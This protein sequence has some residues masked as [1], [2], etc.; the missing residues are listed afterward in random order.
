MGINKSFRRSYGK[1]QSSSTSFSSTSFSSSSSPSATDDNDDR[2]NNHHD[3][4]SEGSGRRHKNQ[5]RPSW[6]KWSSSRSSSTRGGRKTK[7][8][9]EDK[10][11][12]NRNN[13][14]N[15]DDDNDNDA[16]GTKKNQ[17]QQPPISPSASPEL[18][19]AVR[20]FEITTKNVFTNE[21]VKKKYKRLSL[22]HHPDRNGNEKKSI[23]EMQKIN[24]YLELLEEELDR[25]V[26]ETKSD[27]KVDGSEDDP[28][29][30]PNSN[31]SDN[32]DEEK[33]DNKDKYKHAKSSR[34]TSHHRRRSRS[35]F[36]SRS[37]TTTRQGHESFDQ[38][39]NSK[40][41][42]KRRRCNS[43]STGRR[44]RKM[45]QQQERQNTEREPTNEGEDNNNNTNN[46]QNMNDF[47]KK[48]RRFQRKNGRHSVREQLETAWGR[49][50]AHDIYNRQVKAYRDKV[51]S[52]EREGSLFRDD[53]FTI[54]G[55]MEAPTKP[56]HALMECCNED[57]V[58][59]MRLGQTKS[60]TEIVHQEI[61]S[62]TEE[63]IRVKARTSVPTDIGQGVYRSTSTSSNRGGVSF[64]LDKSYHKQI[65][66]VLSRPLD[67]DGNTVLHYAVYL[68]DHEA[69]AYLTQVARR[70][71]F[72]AKF[73]V[74]TNN[75]NLTA[76]NYVEGC[77]WD[78][79]TVPT[80][81]TTLT[82]EALDRLQEKQRKRTTR[83]RNERRFSE[84]PLADPLF[85]VILCILVGR[86]VTCS[87]WVASRV[88][89]ALA[90]FAGAGDCKSD[91]A[92]A[93]TTTTTSITTI[94]LSKTLFFALHTG[95]YLLVGIISR[96][97]DLTE[98]FSDGIP[99]P[100]QLQ[101]VV[102]ATMVPM[103]VERKQHLRRPLRCI[104]NAVVE[105]ESALIV[106]FDWI[107]SKKN[108]II[109]GS[110]FSTSGYYVQ[111]IADF[112]VLSIPFLIVQ[113]L[114]LCGAVH[115]TPKMQA[116]AP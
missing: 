14:G 85:D 76:C 68:E 26:E 90:H 88:I 15:R 91:A 75:R 2:N 95:W 111:T 109:L 5:R 67:E 49:D 51:E 61:N 32:E 43:N 93:T 105:V 56:K 28:P 114:L 84:H 99:F 37:S 83:H 40:S 108:K 1:L 17:P 27:E 42:K 89:I 74:S 82:N 12:V 47:R 19:E 59:A 60:A 65:L 3:A 98:A 50:R 9:P 41:P 92:N 116:M 66:R 20:Y 45:E 4:Y 53:K 80:L 38:R 24:N 34:R 16:A 46:T 11:K 104:A 39:R 7:I 22:I 23:Q 52:M 106:G 81:V 30:T 103:F 44:E 64:R 36:R 73:I 8:Q 10:G 25:L 70:Y 35:I 18:Q 72:F 48:Q 96:G 21:F 115:L 31:S 57:A 62:A 86:Y 58:V 13:D 100:W 97:K 69:I 110:S 71:K 77:T 87:G 33:N 29:V 113:L 107:L 63:W 78:N 102:V 94:R 6:W 101:L 54:N 79:C 112:A 55:R